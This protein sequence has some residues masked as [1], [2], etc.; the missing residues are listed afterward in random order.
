MYIVTFFLQQIH[1]KHM[2][3]RDNLFLCPRTK[4]CIPIEIKLVLFD[5]LLWS[6]SYIVFYQKNVKI[7]KFMIFFLNFEN[8]YIAF[9]EDFEFF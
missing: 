7:I 8:Y 6:I 3:T 4:Q 9:F 1:P 5:D 2:I